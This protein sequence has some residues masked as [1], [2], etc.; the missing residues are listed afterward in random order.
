MTAAKYRLLPII[1]STEES[2]PAKERSEYFGKFGIKSN[3][4][5]E[6][7]PAIDGLFDMSEDISYIEIGPVTIDSQNPPSLTQ[8]YL[9][10]NP[11]KQEPI[12]F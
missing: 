10:I 6:G 12:E 9:T 11:H 5:K 8:K 1:S 7:G 3:F 4:C 2:E